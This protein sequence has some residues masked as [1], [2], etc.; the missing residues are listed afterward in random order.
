MCQI[1]YSSLGQEEEGE[2]EIELKRNDKTPSRVC[3]L[4]DVLMYMQT[5]AK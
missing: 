4:L 1:Y 2:E 5:L 3:P